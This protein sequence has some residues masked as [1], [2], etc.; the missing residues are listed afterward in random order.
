MHALYS[1]D[2]ALKKI[3]LFRSFDNH[4]YGLVFDINQQTKTELNIFFDTIP[5]TFWYDSI[6]NS[7]EKLE[8]V[9]NAVF[10][11]DVILDV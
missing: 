7:M 10:F 9:V 8:K 11:L 4:P 1:V 2:I 5:S 6:Y 3:H